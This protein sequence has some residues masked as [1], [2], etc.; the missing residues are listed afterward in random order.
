MQSLKAENVWSSTFF[1]VVLDFPREM[2]DTTR[3]GDPPPLPHGRYAPGAYMY[4]PDSYN[5]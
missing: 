1:R 5:E 2:L 4:M 3:W